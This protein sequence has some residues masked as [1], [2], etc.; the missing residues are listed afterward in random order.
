MS[1]DAASHPD[2]V[3]LCHQIMDEQQATITGLQQ[4]MQQL[5]HYVEQL[6]RSRYGPRSERIDPNQLQLF[7]PPA[8]QPS[9]ESP[10]TE[11]T[12]DDVVVVK[13]HRRRGG[14]RN[15]LPDHLPRETVEHDLPEAQKSCPGC[16]QLRQRIG[17][18]TSEQLEFVPAVL[19]VIEHVRWKYACRTCK[20]YVAV[21]P[22]ADKPLEKGLPGPG[23]LS[24]IV[25]SKYADHLPLYRLEDVFARAGVELS[26][27][28]LCRW[29]LQT[30]E[31]LE[32]LYRLLIERVRSSAVIHTDDTPVP[33]LDPA[34]PRTRTARL[35]VY[36][37]DWR[38]PYT[39]YDY[40]ISRRRDGPVEFLA[41]FAGDL[42]A[43][44]F[45]GCDGIYAGGQVRQVPCWAHARRKFF[46]ARTVQPEPAHRAL[47]YIGRLYGVERTAQEL[48]DRTSPSTQSAWWDWHGARQDLRQSQSRPVLAEFHGWLQEAQWQ[49]LPK[50]PVGRAIGYV[51]PRWEGLTR[52]CEDGA[53][54]ID[55]NLSERMVRP[56]AIGRKNY[57]FLGSDNGGTAAA[58]L[59]SVLA[60]AKAN[61]VEPFAYVR[62]LLVQFS[63]APS[64]NLQKLLPDVWLRSHPKS[65][66]A[67]SR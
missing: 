33:V 17:C 36:C 52:Y 47:A 48:A 56:V 19:K 63:G 6:L 25:V 11:A 5:E 8:E 43:D 23:L 42:Q 39:V 21:A 61:Q 3:S 24:A 29:A 65:R 40:T 16:G 32:P 34:L 28:T 7:E 44:A 18:E 66:R 62:D 57:L 54:A 41:G 2:D 45:A 55:N 31:L 1:T 14:G 26:R 12:S 20:E 4:R 64:A 67:W 60:S 53:L 10:L 13:E 27:S 38:N 30:A 51:L 58:I 22:P 37:G 49:V 35:W 50:S 9:E 46:E 15:K 59:Y